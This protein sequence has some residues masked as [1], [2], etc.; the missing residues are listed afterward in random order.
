[1]SLS[2][3]DTN[4]T[5]LGRRRHGTDGPPAQQPLDLHLDGTLKINDLI[6]NRA[7]PVKHAERFQIPDLREELL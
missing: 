7:T 1:M 2:T 5:L 4:G 3:S 6:H